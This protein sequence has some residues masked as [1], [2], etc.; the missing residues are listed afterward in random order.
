MSGHTIAGCSI[1]AV[2]EARGVAAAVVEGIAPRGEDWSRLAKGFDAWFSQELPDVARRIEQ[3]L[4]SASVEKP[5][6][7]HAPLRAGESIGVCKSP[8]H[9]E[10]EPILSERASG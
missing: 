10:E 6:Q 5:Q 3:E 1:G 9:A 7:P 2:R 4:L 8:T